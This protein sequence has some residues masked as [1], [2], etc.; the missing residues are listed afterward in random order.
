MILFLA[1][2]ATIHWPSFR[3]EHANGIAEGRTAVS[4]NADAAAGAQKNIRWKTPIPGL[5][6]S[7]PVVW[8]GRVF[9]TTAIS[10]EG[11]APLK[12]GLYGSGDSAND[13]ST[14]KWVVYCLDKKTGKVLWERVARESKPRTRRHTKATHANSTPAVDGKRVIAFFGSE[15]VYAYDLNGKLL[16]SKDLGAFDVGPQGYEYQWGTASSPVL[17]EDQLILQCDQK[18]GSFLAVFSAAD[19]RELWRVGRDGVSNHSWATPAVVRAAGRTQVVCNGWP[20]IAGY[21]L[22]DGKE[23]WRLKSEGDI[24][25]PT[26]VLGGGL[27]YVTNA[28]GGG[29]PL[30]AIH[31]DALGDIT[32][33]AGQRTSAGLAWSEPRNGA[34]MQT[35]VIARGVVYSCSDRGVLKAYDAVTGKLHYTQ[36][37]G[38]GATGFSSSPVL[39]DRKLYFAGEEGEVYVVKEG[40]AFELLG[41]NLLGE[42]AMATPAVSGNTLYYR[43]RGHVIAIGE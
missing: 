20:Y 30:Y 7:S 4:W 34:Y 43:T 22:A 3:G 10:S 8:G 13:N 25:A 41:K 35:P 29:A 6:H 23:L 16:W 38:E 12:V 27:I 28:H 21:A 17:F 42:I 31:P 37:L 26:P 2:A 24:P 11:E 40:I 39:V 9:V 32:P 36:R 18:K 33:T 5:A 1:L 19:G 14:Q 15:G